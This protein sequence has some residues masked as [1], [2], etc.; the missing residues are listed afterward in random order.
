MNTNA[1]VERIRTKRRLFQ[2]TRTA[3]TLDLRQNELERKLAERKRQAERYEQR[4]GT[5][6]KRSV[7]ISGVVYPAYDKAE[8]NS[9]TDRANYRSAARAYA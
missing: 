5:A 6:G 9:G 4:H 3:S 8:G 1:N 7:F 2:F